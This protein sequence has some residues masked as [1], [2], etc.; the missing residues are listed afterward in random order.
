[1]I[2]GSLRTI[3]TQISI[4]ARVQDVLGTDKETSERSHWPFQRRQV[5]ATDHSRVLREKVAELCV[6]LS[7]SVS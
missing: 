4:R 7:E 3:R 5:E 1:M 2:L 6:V